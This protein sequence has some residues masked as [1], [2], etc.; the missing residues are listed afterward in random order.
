MSFIESYWIKGVLIVFLP[1]WN[2]WGGM[3]Y[4]YCIMR[5][6]NYDFLW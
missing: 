1:F 4:K 5:N 2:N 3:L 6:A